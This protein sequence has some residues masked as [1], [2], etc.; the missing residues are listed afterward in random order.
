MEGAGP[1]PR[2]LTMCV[3]ANCDSASRD[4]RVVVSCYSSL[5]F[6]AANPAAGYTARPMPGTGVFAESRTGYLERRANGS[7][8]V[9][10]A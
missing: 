6:L 10:F 1:A 3:R 7:R 2:H 4:E 5:I 9:C 8:F